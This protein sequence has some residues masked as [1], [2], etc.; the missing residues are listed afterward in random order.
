MVL[1]SSPVAVTLRMIC[2][3]IEVW[4]ITN[5]LWSHFRNICNQYVYESISQI[6]K[7][8]IYKD[9]IRK[10]FIVHQSVLSKKKWKLI[11]CLRKSWFF[12]SNHNISLYIVFSETYK[13]IKQRYIMGICKRVSGAFSPFQFLQIIIEYVIKLHQLVS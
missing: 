13:Y 2:F 8:N 6:P 3:Y 5:Y 9:L 11:K 12:Q 4:S 10:K 7:S 1:S